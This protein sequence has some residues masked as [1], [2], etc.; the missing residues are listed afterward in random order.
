MEEVRELQRLG[1]KRIL[2]VAIE[3]QDDQGLGLSNEFERYHQIPMR[4]IVEETGVTQY[5]REACDF[6]SRPILPT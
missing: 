6:L 5:I 2:N 1:V 4:D 3:C